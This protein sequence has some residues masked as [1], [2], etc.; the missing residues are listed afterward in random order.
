[1]KRNKIYT[2]L[3][4]LK[5]NYKIHFVHAK[6]SLTA[7]SVMHANQFSLHTN[8]F[9]YRSRQAVIHTHAKTWISY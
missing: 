6:Q 5:L 9:K 2:L 8:S 7:I 1:M 3:R 4:A